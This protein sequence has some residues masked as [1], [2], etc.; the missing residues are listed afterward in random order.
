MTLVKKLS[1]MKKNFEEEFKNFKSM[2]E[3]NSYNF[4]NVMRK[5]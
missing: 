1:V 3:K 4:K 5:I 2:I